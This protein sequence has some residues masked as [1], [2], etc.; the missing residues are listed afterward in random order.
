[1]YIALASVS[2]DPTINPVVLQRIA[3]ALEIQIYRDVGPFWQFAG[4]PVKVFGSIDAIPK[5]AAPLIVFDDP[6][7]SGAL[8][9]HDVDPTGRAYGRA[10]WKIIQQY[11]GTILTGAESLSVTLSHEALEMIGDPYV[12]FWAQMPDGGLECLELCDRVEADSYPID[13]VA[14]SNFVGPRAFRNGNGPW[15]FMRLLKSP[16]EIRPGGYA[17]RMKGG[18]ITNVWGEGFAQWKKELKELPSSRTARRHHDPNDPPAPPTNEGV[19][20]PELDD[21]TEPNAP[22][23]LDEG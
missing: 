13:G 11:G 17:I 10:F 1:M 2:K 23:A 8:G 4:M 3:A 5:D 14:V 6:D 22:P 19:S 21:P 12:N 16:W 18:K 15:D 20:E 7:Q 9:W